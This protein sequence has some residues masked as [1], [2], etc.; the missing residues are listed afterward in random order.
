MKKIPATNSIY[1]HVQYFMSDKGELLLAKLKAF[2]PQQVNK[3]Q[4]IGF[5]VFTYTQHLY[6]IRDSN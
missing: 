1:V 6:I 2:V 3:Q 5:H 4:A